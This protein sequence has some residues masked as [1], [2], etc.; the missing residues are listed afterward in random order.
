MII[1]NKPRLDSDGNTQV[2][3]SLV[4][5]IA[6]WLNASHRSRIS[7]GMNLSAKW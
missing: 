2:N 1:H 7:V 4:A 3:N 6:L 5:V